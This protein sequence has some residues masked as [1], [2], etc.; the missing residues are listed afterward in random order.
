[1][2]RE[3]YVCEARTAEQAER[4]DEMVQAMKN[5]VHL[6]VEL[7]VEERNLLSVAY[8][9][10]IGSRRSSWRIISNMKDEGDHPD[11]PEIME[12]LRKKIEDELVEI[13]KEVTEI[14]DKEL[15]PKATTSESKV[16]YYKMKGDYYRYLA[17]FQENEERSHSAEKSAEAYEEASGLLYLVFFLSYGVSFLYV[18]ISTVAFYLFI[19]LY[20]HSYSHR[21]SQSYSPHSFGSSFKPISFFL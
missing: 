17:E 6:G 9:N 11:K 21:R 15:I 10:V 12:K 7:T 1:M 3:Y 20:A 16:F 8:K 2:S 5:V 4:F 18:K 13:C 14:L 19:I